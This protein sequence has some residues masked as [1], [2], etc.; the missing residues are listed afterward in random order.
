MCASSVR[1]SGA[2]L[3]EHF[4]SHACGTSAGGG[5]VPCRGC[6]RSQPHPR[7]RRSGGHHHQG[8]GH[9]RG[10]RTRGEGDA[11][12]NRILLTRSAAIPT[13][14]PSTVRCR[15][16]SRASSLATRGCC[17]RPTRVLQVFHQS[18]WEQQAPNRSDE[19]FCR[20]IGLV[21]VIEGVLWGRR[22]AAGL[23]C[24]RRRRR[25][26]SNVAR[27]RRRCCGGWACIVWLMRGCRFGAVLLTAAGR[28]P[29][30]IEFAAS[31]AA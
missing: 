24:S 17:C 23:S 8:G 27:G 7:Q 21:M 9:A 1:I 4:R 31:D 6:R 22:A 20:G 11:E 16:T 2:E 29:L 26:R 13:S 30:E 28:R 18:A 10:E 25:R 12:R 15:P 5:R 3:Q 14:S 19:R